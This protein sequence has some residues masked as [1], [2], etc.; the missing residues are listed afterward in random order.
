MDD[1]I[2]L[3]FG[4]IFQD[5]TPGRGKKFCPDC[6]NYVGAKTLKCHCGYEF[7]KGVK[8]VPPRELSKEEIA[9]KNFV[10]QVGRKLYI[11][12]TPRG[13]CPIKL[14][15]LTQEDIEKW[16][17][18][19]IEHG[20]QNDITY[21]PRALRY[22]LRDFVDIHSQNYAI[23]KRILLEWAHRYSSND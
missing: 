2:E 11:I 13:P 21:L 22:W 17:D 6:E 16:A 20:L 12:S 10:K 4:E 3:D 19:V 23:A 14:D 7:E 5:D 9:T 18:A 8:H 15:G 1:D